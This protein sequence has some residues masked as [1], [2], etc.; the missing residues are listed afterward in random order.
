MA[1]YNDS[2][3]DDETHSLSEAYR[4]A[5]INGASWIIECADIEGEYEY[6]FVHDTEEFALYEMWHIVTRAAPHTAIYSTLL[7]IEEQKGD[8]CTWST[9]EEIRNGTWK[10]RGQR[11]REYLASKGR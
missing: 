9:T 8:M 7:P 2:L 11:A 5:K 1:D 10:I 4:E 6:V 3:E